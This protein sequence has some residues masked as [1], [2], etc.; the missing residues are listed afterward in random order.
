M[1]SFP[2]LIFVSVKCCC[3]FMTHDQNK[4]LVRQFVT[5]LT[6]VMS[7]FFVPVSC[8]TTKQFLH[9]KVS[10]STMKRNLTCRYKQSMMH[11][12]RKVHYKIDNSHLG[13]IL[14]IRSHADW[15]QN[16]HWVYQYDNLSR[17]G[18]LMRKSQGFQA[19]FPHWSYKQF[20]RN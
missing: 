1:L 7:T 14:N 3:T 10:F 15:N 12:Q 4:L 18:L 20:H 2:F 11:T 13:H 5:T 8:K 9:S 6:H 19:H 16:H 17:W